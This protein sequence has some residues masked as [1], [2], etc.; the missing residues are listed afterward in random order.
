MGATGRDTSVALIADDDPIIRDLLRSLLTKAN[1]LVVCAAS[2]NEALSYAP[3]LNPSLA[4]LDLAM[5]DGNG[6]ETTVALRRLPN[7]QNVPILILTSYHTDKAL[8]AARRAGA[9][10]FLCKP[11]VPSELLRRIADLTADCSEP[12][13]TERLD[14]KCALLHIYRSMQPPQNAAPSATAV[15]D[16]PPQRRRILVADDDELTRNVATGILTHAG[17][18]AHSVA[19]GQEALAA[20]IRDQ[21]DMV[22]M[23][24][25]MP[26]IDGTNATRLIR[27]LPGAKR[28]TP[29][30]AMTTNNF[31]R[32]MRELIDAGMNGYLTKPI[33]GDSLLA[34][35]R[36]NLPPLPAD[37]PARTLEL[38]RLKDA[39]K[40]SPP[41]AMARL[42]DELA[43]LINDILPPLQG[44]VVVKPTELKQ[45]LRNLANV[46]GT[47][48]CTALSEAAG[49]IDAQPTLTDTMR[50]RF[51]T[52]VRATLAA[53]Q[54][55]RV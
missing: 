15:E 9:T 27:S 33:R 51:L 46:A 45:R 16:E 48:G 41:G 24:V 47:L 25:R 2:G 28:L 5:P 8:M 19:D 3:H 17:Y 30:I 6:V 10:G 42:L 21:Y 52:T 49:A 35:V 14:Q 13:A 7:W 38:D 29:I 43:D 36:E 50:Q 40:R 34:C 11:F 31:Q 18:L 37:Q 20:V 53:V 23:D 4:I 22:L 44:W 39:V 32:F 12:V 26:V 54:P 1:Y 55:Y